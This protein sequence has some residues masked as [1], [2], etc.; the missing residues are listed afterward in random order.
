M[1]KLKM[2]Y[3]G[4][5]GHVISIARQVET[6]L[7]QVHTITHAIDWAQFHLLLQ[8]AIAMQ[9]VMD[10]C[11]YDCPVSNCTVH[12]FLQYFSSILESSN[13]HRCDSK[14]CN[15]SLIMTSTLLYFMLLVVILTVI[16][17]VFYCICKEKCRCNED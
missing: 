2:I 5:G 13:Y 7:V 4:Y 15:V 10:H 11:C 16:M 9:S 1:N 3:G 12:E 14:V 6:V 8:V 17:I